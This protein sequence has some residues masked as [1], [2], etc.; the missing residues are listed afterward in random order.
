[1][2]CAH[3]TSSPY[4]ALFVTQSSKFFALTRLVRDS[5][6]CRILRLI[7]PCSWLVSLPNSS[8]YLAL[9]VTRQSAEF[10]AL[11]ALVPLKVPINCLPPFC[12]VCGLSVCRRNHVRSPRTTRWKRQTWYC[13]IHSV[14][15]NDFHAMRLEG[16]M[17]VNSNGITP[18][19]CCVSSVS[20]WLL[21]PASRD[22]SS[23]LF[24]EF[25]ELSLRSCL[26][27]CRERASTNCCFLGT[28]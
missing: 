8:P 17:S 9:F 3:Y 28:H 21:L 12:Q 22:E 24:D 4:L 10:F 1:M 20:T 25:K 18:A 27:C 6:I 5:S 13:D 14:T 7:S 11:S 2:A 16:W 23:A 15:H 26:N 19:C